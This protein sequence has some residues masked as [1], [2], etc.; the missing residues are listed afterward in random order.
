MGSIIAEMVG[1]RKYDNHISLTLKKKR[2]ALFSL[3]GFISGLDFERKIHSE[4]LHPMGDADDN[5]S[6]EKYSSKLYEDK[7]FS[8]TNDKFDVEIF[9]GSK[10]IFVSVHSKNLEIDKVNST[11]NKYFIWGKPMITPTKNTILSNN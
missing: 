4:L 11:I 7:H 9:F 6:R 3:I 2:S 10:R 8:F 5:Y 1:I